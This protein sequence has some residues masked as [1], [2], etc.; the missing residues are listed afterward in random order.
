[1][2]QSDPMESFPDSLAAHGSTPPSG[3][4]FRSAQRYTSCR[5]KVHTHP[6]PTRV[7][8]SCAQAL[9][10][11]QV[12]D[13]DLIRRIAGHDG[14]AMHRLYVRYRAKVFNYVHRLVPEREDVDDLV[15]QAFLDVW[16]AA[17]TFEYRSSVSTWLLAIARFKA[18]HHFRKRR[19]ERIDDVEIPEVIDDAESPDT[20]IDRAKMNDV[21]RACVGKLHPA[22]REVV[23][24]VY[25]QER[26]VIEA[27]EI[28]GIPCATVK[29]RMFYARKDLAILLEGAGIN[30]AAC[31]FRQCGA[32]RALV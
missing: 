19:R 3:E 29:T 26:S 20:M 22:R 7:I 14:A 5:A 12:S 17:G 24:L 6:R 16:H 4:I 31:E 11:D 23:D 1:M 27:S 8:R 10:P 15:S 25:Y 9:A 30:R 18:L 32:S 21:L 2:L 28:L 13:D